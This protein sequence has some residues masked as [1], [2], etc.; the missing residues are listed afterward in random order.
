M[1]TVEQDH[2]NDRPSDDG[3]EGEGTSDELPKKKKK[4]KKHQPASSPEETERDSEL[5]PG[6]SAVNCEGERSKK[7]KREKELNG[8]LAE[9]SE[10]QEG[11][12]TTSID[13]TG[14]PPKKKKKKKKQ[15]KDDLLRVEGAGK[16]AVEDSQEAVEKNKVP[17]LEY[18]GQVR[19]ESHNGESSE[20]S[21][22]P[23]V[24]KRKKKAKAL[25]VGVSALDDSDSVVKVGEEEGVGPVEVALSYINGGQCVEGVKQRKGKER[26]EEEGEEG[27][28]EEGVKAK[29][30]L[31]RVQCENESAAATGRLESVANTKQKKEKSKK[32]KKHK[33]YCV[34]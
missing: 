18:N 31:K 23:S 2:S 33:H 6:G 16:P 7:R 27:E 10:E 21:K 20:F 26:G 13:V 25:T 12:Q 9:R 8:K 5:I 22:Q 14:E 28:R 11:E 30:K 1:E 32:H 3:G 34:V 17:G 19:D 4:K 15:E 29:K 24:K